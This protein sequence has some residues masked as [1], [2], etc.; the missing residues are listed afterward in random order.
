MASSSGATCCFLVRCDHGH[1]Q[2]KTPVGGIRGVR[3]QGE[4]IEMNIVRRRRLPQA[5][6]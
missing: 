5:R 1:G 3:D 4:R 2:V 6:A